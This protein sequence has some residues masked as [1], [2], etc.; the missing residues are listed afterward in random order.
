MPENQGKNARRRI[1]SYGLLS[2]YA[3]LMAPDGLLYHATDVKELHDWMDEACEEHPLFVRVPLD[4]L[5]DDLCIQA[6][7][8]ETEESKRAARPTNIS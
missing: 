3:Y 8:S 1:I 7:T 4:E 2:V 5:Q 6:V